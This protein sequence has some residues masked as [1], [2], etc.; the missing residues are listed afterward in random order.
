MSLGESGLGVRRRFPET[1]KRRSDPAAMAIFSP[2][3]RPSR[4]LPVRGLDA[5]RRAPLR[6][7]GCRSRAARRATLERSPDRRASAR[8]RP[9]RWAGRERATPVAARAV[10]QDASESFGSAPVRG[11]DV[12]SNRRLTRVRRPRMVSHSWSSLNAISRMSPPQFGHA[13]GNS[14]PTRAMS[15]AQAIREVSCERG[16]SRVSQQPPV[17][18]PPPPCPPVTA[19][20][21]L[22]MLPMARAVTADL[23]L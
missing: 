6:G 16:F 11:Q 10:R 9:S 20:R 18:C 5:S 19:S 13:K 3:R 1:P 2:R 8:A 15:F 14:S 17:A 21:C 4:G 7:C 22:P 23:S 12:R